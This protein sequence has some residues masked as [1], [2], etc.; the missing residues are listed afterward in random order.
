MARCNQVTL[1]QTFC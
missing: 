1:V